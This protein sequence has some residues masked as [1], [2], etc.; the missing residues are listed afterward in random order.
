MTRIMILNYVKNYLGSKSFKVFLLKDFVIGGKN[1]FH[2]LDL[3]VGEWQKYKVL[4]SNMNL[5]FK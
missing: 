3:E 5:S 2:F 4:K 1:E